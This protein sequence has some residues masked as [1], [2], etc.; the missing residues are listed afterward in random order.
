MAMHFKD[1]PSLAFRDAQRNT[2]RYC[3]QDSGRVDDRVYSDYKCKDYCP[4]VFR[5]FFCPFSFTDFSFHS[6]LS[7]L[8][9]F[10]HSFIFLHA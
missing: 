9:V 5:L 3:K 8:S 1:L 4:D 7:C 6:Y 2:I 10:I